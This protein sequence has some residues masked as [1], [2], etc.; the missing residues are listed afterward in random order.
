MSRATRLASYN[1]I[2]RE[3][4]ARLEA[5]LDSVIEPYRVEK[6]RYLRAGTA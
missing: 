1:R 2:L 4:L 5:E 6:L 3:Q